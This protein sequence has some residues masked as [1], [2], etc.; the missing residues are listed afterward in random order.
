V[1]QTLFNNT[2]NSLSLNFI[3]SIAREPNW[4]GQKFIGSPLA[5]E[6]LVCKISPQPH[7][8]SMKN[9][10]TL[11]SARLL[12]ALGGSIVAN[13][14]ASKFS[15]ASDLPAGLVVK[16]NFCGA[17]GLGLNPAQDKNFH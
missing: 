5:R 3:C 10:T 13:V 4:L 12:H 6:G 17:E 16:D 9:L 7:P 14:C 11:L 15:P 1:T 2:V 8:S